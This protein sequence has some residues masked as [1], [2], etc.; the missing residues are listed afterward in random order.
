MQDF[1]RHVAS[2]LDDA[3]PEPDHEIAIE[4]VRALTRPR[5]ASAHRRVRIAAGRRAPAPHARGSR[6]AVLGAAAAAV[7]VAGGTYGL[8]R[9]TDRT[10]NTPPAA[11]QPAG[12]TT[13][14]WR[15][16]G[17]TLPGAAT[18]PASAPLYFTFT[19]RGSTDHA[20][21]GAPTRIT[22][23]RISFGTWAGDAVARHVPHLDIAQSNV[24]F[25]LMLGTMTWSIAGDILTFHRAGAGSLTFRRSNY[26][27]HPP[28]YGSVNGRFLAIGGPAPGLPRPKPGTGTVVFTDARTG[29]AQ[30]VDT[31][32]GGTFGSA[33]PPGSYTVVGH[34]S[35]YQGGRVGCAAR[36]S[37]TVHADTPARI[38]VYCE[39]R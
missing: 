38:N 9:T 35:S 36:G 23:A 29:R 4:D 32:T 26:N 1:E 13:S 21:D 39:E 16:T 17:I 14:V 33:I 12:L 3:V 27:L 22:G 31:R 11:V 15:L 25:H 28:S 5:L 18:E 7:V 37:V 34:I 10:S 2:L 24:V 20:G 8:I 19:D 30:T 6:L